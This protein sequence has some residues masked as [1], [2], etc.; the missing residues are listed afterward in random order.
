MKIFIKNFIIS[1]IITTILLTF[2]ATGALAD[3]LFYIKP[4]DYIFKRQNTNTVKTI[5]SGDS[6]ELVAN[7]AEQASTSV[8]TIAIKEVVQQRGSQS[9]FDLFNFGLLPDRPSEP[10]QR[11]IGTGFVVENSYVITNKHVVS[12]T[13]SSY[14]IIDKD[15]NE[16]EAEKIYRDPTSDL[17]I[18]KVK[19]FNVNALSLGDSERLRVG[20]Q[21]IAIGTALGEFRHTVTTGVI[22]GLGRG[23]TAGDPF[24]SSTEELQNVIQTDAAINP[25]NSGGP[26]LNLQGEVIGVNVAVSQSG[27]NIGF[28]LPINLVKATIDN[29]N[30]TGQFERPFL[31]VRYQ[32]VSQ[33]AAIANEIP[34]GAY[35]V[36]VL[37]ASPAQKS[38]IEE[39]D[40]I[41]EFDGNSLVDKDLANFINKKKVGDKVK[42]KYFRWNESN[43]QQK[44]YETVVELTTS[45]N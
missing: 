21:V 7:V 22:S 45:T 9:L 36:E 3:R 8:V 28:A 27:E 29:F 12:D 24:G 30:E 34:A 39:G 11:D 6:N 35:V 5:I 18:I 10:V 26:L 2:F 25:G 44:N 19:N 43:S 31:G 16:F 42:V 13:K 1:A 23:I 40:I 17:A 37:D 38:G 33:K 4:L 15:N 32:N 20:Q 41:T 14:I